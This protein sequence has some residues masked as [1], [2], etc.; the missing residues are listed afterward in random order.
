MKFLGELSAGELSLGELSCNPS[1]AISVFIRLRVLLLR[2]SWQTQRKI[3]MF[4]DNTRQTAEYGLQKVSLSKSC[5]ACPD[6]RQWGCQRTNRLALNI[7]F[8]NEQKGSR[9]DRPWRESLMICKTKCIKENLSFLIIHTSV[10]WI[11][12]FF[13]QNYCSQWVYVMFLIILKNRANFNYTNYFS[14]EY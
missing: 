13:L 1:C 8:N 7:F 14:F 9:R 4:V 6:Q 5:F 3:E 10:T 12:V 11:R 2:I